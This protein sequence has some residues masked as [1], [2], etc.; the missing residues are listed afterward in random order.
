[1]ALHVQYATFRRACPG[2]SGNG[3]A[4]DGNRAN[5]V[6]LL[7]TARRPGGSTTRRLL[8]DE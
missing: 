2:V 4:T 5:L 8:Q 7:S 6:H 1:M 3:R